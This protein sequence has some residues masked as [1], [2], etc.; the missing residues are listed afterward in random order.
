MISTILRIGAAVW[1]SCFG[2]AGFAQDKPAN[3]P[4]RPVRIVVGIVPGAGLDQTTRMVAQLITDR[5][6]QNV[7]VDNRPGGGTVIA[8]ELGAQ[9]APDGYTLLM[10]TDT[11]GLLGA[12][13]R[14]AFDPRK[15]YD[16]IV[17]V[18]QQPYVLVAN[19]ALPAKTMKELVAHSRAKPNTVSYGSSGVGTTLHVGMERLAALTGASLV[20]IPYKGTALA[21]LAVISGE[22][23]I[24]P[25]SSIAT[26]PHIKSGKLRGLATMGLKRLPVMPEL[27]TAAEALNLPGFRIT[28]T[29]NLFAPA[30]T[31]R[32]ILNGINRIVTDHMHTP[33]MVQ[34]LVNE[35]AEP[36][37]RMTP[38]EFKVQFA[39]DY[40][41]LEK[42]VAK[43][44]MKFY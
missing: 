40:V 2:T 35:G 27:P 14:I 20:H 32:P 10:A 3:Y 34:K 26:L 24:L 43:L 19:H 1:V 41:E 21:L 39:R 12:L 22:I 15:V 29:Y 44:N 8:A 17:Q 6:G 11:L 38:D 23:Q 16:P 25:G 42:Q 9:A 30:G 7:V 33:Q 37:E 5:W 18:T 13:K 31:P 36:G 28:N 4:L